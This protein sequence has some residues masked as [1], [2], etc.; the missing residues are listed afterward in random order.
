VLS[1]LVRREVLPRN[2]CRVYK[3]R[4]GRRR[5]TWPSVRLAPPG[6]RGHRHAIGRGH[7]RA[8]GAGLGRAVAGSRRGVPRGRVEGQGSGGL[9]G[10]AALSSGPVQ[11]C[12]GLEL[13]DVEPHTLADGRI[14]AVGRWQ[15]GSRSS[16]AKSRPPTGSTR[17][18]SSRSGPAGRTTSSSW[19]TKG[20]VHGL[21]GGHRRVDGPA[22]AGPRACAA[23]TEGQLHDQLARPLGAPSAS[24]M[25]WRPISTSSSSRENSRSPAF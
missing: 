25:A 19:A 16:E 22:D 9:E 10:V 13:V 24:S 18:G 3:G 12:D 17:D 4:P 6:R 11:A 23:P 5:P 7:R 14:V 21:H 8:V 2:Y 20:P 15:L 1:E